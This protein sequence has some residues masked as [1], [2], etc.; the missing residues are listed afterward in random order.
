[1][2][3]APIENFIDYTKAF[4]LSKMLMTAIDINLFPLLDNKSLS[5]KE[6][7]SR[8]NVDSK[9]GIE[10]FNALVAYGILQVE[11]SKFSLSPIAKSVLP[12]YKNIKSWNEEM[13]VTFSALVDLTQ[14]LK[15]GDY[16]S[17]ALSKYWAYKKALERHEIDSHAYSEAMD[18]SIGKICKSIIDNFDFTSYSHLLD[19]GGGYGQFAIKIAEKIS[20]LKLTVV[21]LPSV[22]AVTKKIIAARGLTT[23]INCVGIDFFKDSP[24]ENPDIITLIRVL[25]DWN[26]E[27]VKFLLTRVWNILANEGTILISEPIID[28][29]KPKLDK[30]SCATA[31]MLSLMGGK[32]RKISD[33]KA[34]LKSIGFEKINCI[35]INLSIF[36]VISA[37]K[38]K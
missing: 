15:S 23:R 4:I 17:S 33:Y 31:L 10:F 29:R 20:N 13:K 1:M 36:R 11:K 12:S 16:K 6:L 24:P 37:Q 7:I 34:I 9:I 21:D 19:M 38:K 35:D 22:C 18:N 28:D 25:H 8:L 32:R 30:G 26:D 14:I 3:I 27:E 5:I 2:M